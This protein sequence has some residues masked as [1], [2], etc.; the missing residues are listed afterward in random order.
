MSTQ[1]ASEVLVLSEDGQKL[2]V[3]NINKA[4]ELARQQDLDLVTVS[5]KPLVCKIMDEG[6]WKY[7]KKKKGQQKHKTPPMKEMKFGVSIQEHDI[8]TKVKAVQGFL[9]KGSAV[10]ITIEMRGREKSHAEMARIKLTDI[11]S[12]VTGVKCSDIKSTHDSVF[13]TIQSVS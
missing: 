11:L 2:G 9:E 5:D 6:K 13:V 1:V 8:N 3:M 4:R 10:R 12:R 7:Q